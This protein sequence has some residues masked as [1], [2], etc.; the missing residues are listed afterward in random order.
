MAGILA[1]CTTG[2]TYLLLDVGDFKHL[3][4]SYAFHAIECD[5]VAPPVTCFC[6]MLWHQPGLISVEALPIEHL[7]GGWQLFVHQP[8]PDAHV[9]PKLC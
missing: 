4:F 8:Q 3:M 7:H 9:H 1:L 2:N 5:G 6:T